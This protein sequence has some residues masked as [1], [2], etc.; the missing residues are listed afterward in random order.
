MTAGKTLRSSATLVQS[1]A[2]T[3]R[4]GTLA[5]LALLGLSMILPRGVLAQNGLLSQETIDR[6]IQN[7]Q[8]VI[9]STFFGMH[10]N[11]LFDPWPPQAEPFPI[12][13]ANQRLEGSD[14]NW[15]NIEVAPGQY[16]YQYLD[17][18]IAQAV[19]NNVTLMYTF[20]GVPQFYS[21]VPSD[22]GC[23][24]ENGACDPPSDLNED[25]T[26]TD[27]SFI[28]F[29]TSIV[30]HNYELGNP[31]Q[32]WE[33]WNEPN[34]R[35]QWY[36]TC[37]RLKNCYHG[38]SECTGTGG[39]NLCYAQ[40]LRMAADAY[41]IIKAYNPNAVI[42]NPP[43]VGYPGSAELWMSQYLQWLRKGGTDCP[44]SGVCPVPDAMGYHGY[45]NQWVMGDFPIPENEF[46]LIKQVK[47]TL[48]KQKFGSKQMWITEGGWGNIILDGYDDGVL[49]SSF[50][51]RYMLL[52][53]SLG[54]PKAYWYQWDQVG[55]A[56]RLWQ[57]PAQ[58][59]LRLPGY[60]YASVV[61]WTLGATLTN[62]CALQRGTSVWVCKYSRSTPAGYKAVIVWNAKEGSTYLMPENFPQY[63]DLKGNVTQIKG[64]KVQIG[65]WPILLE[66]KN[67][68]TT[69]CQQASLP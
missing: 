20:D 66:N 53:E 61:N 35:R 28:N 25:G 34:Q 69:A 4:L 7:G 46:Q 8:Y 10:M 54:I 57:G 16:D 49:Q 15:W 30:K 64:R 48:I 50:L 27:A 55:G 59:N 65:L 9:P 51:A 5:A 37:E 23:T 56:G 26:G 43:P 13:F 36:P 21:S 2:T 45:L 19:Q 31:I 62:T 11:S 6:Q 38:T 42:L 68:G 58:G 18:W 52:Q 14:V 44:P 24:F 41:P 39:T 3:R 22:A 17:Q 1:A 12:Y 47:S 33:M 63:C 40:L 67:L 60:A 29:V 32:Y